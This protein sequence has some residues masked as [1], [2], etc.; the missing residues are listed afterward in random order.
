MA[1]W[2]CTPQ[3]PPEQPKL[4][5][6]VSKPTFVLLH[7]WHHVRA[8][9]AL[10]ASWGQ[11]LAPF[12]VLPSAAAL[13][14]EWQSSQEGAGGT[15]APLHW[16]LGAREA[17]AHQLLAA[18]HAGAEGSS[19]GTGASPQQRWR[20]HRGARKASLSRGQR[21][22]GAVLGTPQGLIRTLQLHSPAAP[23]PHCCPPQP[24]PG[25]RSSVGCPA[26]PPPAMGTPALAAAWHS[27][28]SAG[29]VGVRAAPG[30][31]RAAFTHWHKGL[32]PARGCVG[33]LALS[34]VGRRRGW[35]CHA[36]DILRAG[37]LGAQ[38]AV[39]MVGWVCCRSGARCETP[40]QGRRTLENSP[41]VSLCLGGGEGAGQAGRCCNAICYA[42]H[43]P[44][45][46]GW[47]EGSLAQGGG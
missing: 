1:D 25:R 13:P 26:Q 5:P 8:Q 45:V 39:G 19:P 46:L 33:T 36:L 4:F 24:L 38:E 9:A 40:P 29:G 47:A 35:Q 30:A 22:A 2:L 32:A 6:G 21:R 23:T 3:S 34:A 12:R 7:G 20:R 16:H 14:R 10:G 27:K 42:Q 43:L 37:G 28:C 11:S 18:W 17:S 41:D 15:A 44:V 31:L